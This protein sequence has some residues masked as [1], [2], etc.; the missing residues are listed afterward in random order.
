VHAVAETQHAGELVDPRSRVGAGH[1]RP[2]RTCPLAGV[3]AASSCAPT[4]TLA[5]SHRR[6]M[7][8]AHIP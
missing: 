2:G 4:T 3:A 8:L 7:P 5:A 6:A 1:Y